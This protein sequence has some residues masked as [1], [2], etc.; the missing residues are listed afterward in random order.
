MRSKPIIG[1]NADYRPT[2]NGRPAYTYVWSGYYESISAAGG[3]WT[4]A[5]LAD[6]RVVERDPIIIKYQGVKIVSAPPPSSGGVVLAEALHV[7][8]EFDLTQMDVD[9]RRH[10]VIEAMRRAY[11]DRAEY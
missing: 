11:R 7:L 2:E 3:I 4:M 6:Y 10:V 1:L 5:D 9:T 8:S